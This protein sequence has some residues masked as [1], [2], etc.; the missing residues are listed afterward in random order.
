MRGRFALRRGAVDGP[1]GSR[2]MIGPDGPGRRALANAAGD[3]KI[4]EPPR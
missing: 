4:P 1:C 3:T 2:R